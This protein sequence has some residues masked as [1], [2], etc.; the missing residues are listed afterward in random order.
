MRGVLGMGASRFA[1][2]GPRAEGTDH[3]S[4]KRIN[5]VCPRLIQ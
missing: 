4:D 3:V 5:V 2:G 1:Q